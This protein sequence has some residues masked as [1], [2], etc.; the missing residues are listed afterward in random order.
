MNGSPERA[1]SR[2]RTLAGED[3]SL[4]DLVYDLDAQLPQ[5]RHTT[6]TQALAELAGGQ[7]DNWRI[8]LAGDV[9]AELGLIGDGDSALGLTVTDETGNTV[10]ALP[11]GVLPALCR[12]TPV[13]NGFFSV[14]VENLG[15]VRNS[16]QLIGN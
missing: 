11:P 3:P 6:A 7:T 10:C 2:F 14:S 1:T 16:Y 8:A 13:R 4:Q 9:P 5:H 15:A 12:F